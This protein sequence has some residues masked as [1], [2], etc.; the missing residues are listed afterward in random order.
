[1]LASITQLIVCDLLRSAC[2]YLFGSGDFIPNILPLIGEDVDL[3]EM[4][5]N[6][7][8]QLSIDPLDQDESDHLA[9]GTFLCCEIIPLDGILTLKDSPNVPLHTLYAAVCLKP[10]LRRKPHKP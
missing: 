5:F 3:W 8:Q 2:S 7:D 9:K 4:V 10:T 6:H 1:M